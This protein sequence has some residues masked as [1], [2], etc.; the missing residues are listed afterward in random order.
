M[1][2]KWLRNNKKGSIKSGK[3]LDI[4]DFPDWLL[5]SEERRFTYW[6]SVKVFNQWVKDVKSDF[7]NWK[8]FDE[9]LRGNKWEIQLE[10]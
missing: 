1:C 10:N 3:S 7:K 6:L 8:L 2:R 5:E 9:F 4:Y